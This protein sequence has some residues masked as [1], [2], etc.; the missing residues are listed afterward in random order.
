MAEA[1]T[2]VCR[3]AKQIPPAISIRTAL[4]DVSNVE[5][6]DSLKLLPTRPRL[7][8]SNSAPKITPR[9]PASDSNRL[10]VK[11]KQ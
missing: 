7:K 8:I 10:L 9:I 4:S 11:E 2:A 6:L 5:V 3:S 1:E